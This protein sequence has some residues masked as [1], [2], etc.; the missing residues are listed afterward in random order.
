MPAAGFGEVVG[1]TSGRLEVQGEGHGAEV[2]GLTPVG[3]AVPLQDVQ[4]AVR[5][6]HQQVLLHG[7]QAARGRARQLLIS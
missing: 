7:L 2:D 3:D 5:R 1:L 4:E 6:G